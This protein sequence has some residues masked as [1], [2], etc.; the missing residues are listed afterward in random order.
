M[1]SVGPSLPLRNTSHL[2]I[3]C[4]PICYPIPPRGIARLLTALSSRICALRAFA[5][6]YLGPSTHIRCLTTH[7]RSMRSPVTSQPVTAVSPQILSEHYVR[8][9]RHNFADQCRFTAALCLSKPSPS[10]SVTL[11]CHSIPLSCPSRPC[12]ACANHHLAKRSFALAFQNV[13]M[14]MPGETQQYN[15]VAVR[16]VAVE[17]KAMRSLCKSGLCGCQSELCYAISEP[18]ISPRCRRLSRHHTAKLRLFKSIHIHASALP[19]GAVR[20]SAF[21]MQSSAYQSRLAPSPADL[22]RVLLF[23]SIAVHI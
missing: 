8:T 7:R 10:L 18:P 9:T 14:P 22:C 13:T 15:A 23:R 5:L 4:A 2:S 1:S 16:I 11:P 6:A 3:A 17:I 21:A 19:A 20:F 12:V